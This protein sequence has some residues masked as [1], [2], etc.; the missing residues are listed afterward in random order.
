MSLRSFAETIRAALGV[1]VLGFFD[2]LP[3][4][5]PVVY[6]QFA[7]NKLSAYELGRSLNTLHDFFAEQHTIEPVIEGR[8][9]FAI[10]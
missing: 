8:M 9:L 4:A 5:W 10:K 3:T 6:R 7:Q 2:F 1:T